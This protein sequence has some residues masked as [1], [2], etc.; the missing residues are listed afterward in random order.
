VLPVEADLTMGERPGRGG[1]LEAGAGAPPA[2]R[3]AVR[4][5]RLART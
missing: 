5:E 2:H 1:A 3:H 4:D